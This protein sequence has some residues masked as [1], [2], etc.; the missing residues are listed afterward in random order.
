MRLRS[1]SP[2]ETGEGDLDCH[3]RR[4]FHRDR[5][6][7]RQQPLGRKSL[8]RDR[9][10]NPIANHTGN[11]EPKIRGQDWVLLASGDTLR[12]S[13]SSHNPS[14]KIQRRSRQLIRGDASMIWRQQ[15]SP[16]DVMCTAHSVLRTHPYHP[17]HQLT[18]W[19]NGKTACDEL[20]PQAWRPQAREYQRACALRGG[21]SCAFQ[22]P[23]K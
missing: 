12:S 10:K 2:R 13:H 4:L 18:A 7:L 6:V 11:L 3:K 17:V 9:M 5:T 8:E 20:T 21:D 14:S 15:Q 16:I 19:D 1:E 22:I 23:A